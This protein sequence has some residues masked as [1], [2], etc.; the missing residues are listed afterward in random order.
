MQ[1]E[2]QAAAVRLAEQQ[3]VQHGPV[4][5]DGQLLDILL[6][7]VEA[8]ITEIGGQGFRVEKQLFLGEPD[9]REDGAIPQRRDGHQAEQTG[10]LP[11]GGRPGLS[12]AGLH[13][14][15]P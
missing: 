15:S 6:R 7:R 1:V 8:G 11:T 5:G 14:D 10:F 3:G 2:D 9:A 13:D 4:N 12:G